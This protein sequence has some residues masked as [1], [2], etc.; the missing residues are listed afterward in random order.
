MYRVSISYNLNG[1]WAETTPAI[2][3]HVVVGAGGEDKD[4]RE[5]QKK[6]TMDHNAPPDAKHQP[7][8]EL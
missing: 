2:F 1:E 3:D 7:K 4:D 8:T 5:H 6:T